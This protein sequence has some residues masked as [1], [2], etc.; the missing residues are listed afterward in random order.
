MNFYLQKNEKF[1][2]LIIDFFSE[3]GDTDL[4]FQLLKHFW[5]LVLVCS[6]NGI[7]PTTLAYCDN[8]LTI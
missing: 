2:M 8:A 1:F 6:P 3:G 5:G 7:E 4:L